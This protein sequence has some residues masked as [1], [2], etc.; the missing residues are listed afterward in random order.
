MRLT[1]R[2]GQRLLCKPISWDDALDE[3]AE[4]FSEAAEQATGSET[5]WPY[6]YAG[7]MGFVMRDGIN[8]LRH[9]KKYS[10]QHSTIC[11]TLAQIRLHHRDRL[12]A[13]TRPSRNGQ[14]RS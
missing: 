5:V 12:V 9:V 13:R 10:G 1:G 11:T 3:V 2:Q 14:E 4:R 7:T 8:R 6:N